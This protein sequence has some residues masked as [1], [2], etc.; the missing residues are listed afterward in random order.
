MR[1]NLESKIQQRMVEWAWSM[2]WPINLLHAIPNGAHLPRKLIKG[3]WVPIHAIRLKKEG[4][5]P[6]VYDLFLPV[7]ANGYHGLYIEVKTPGK[8]NNRS[9][10][11]KE[12]GNSMD[13]LGYKNIVIDNAQDGVD[14]I[15]EYMKGFQK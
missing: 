7:P 1:N 11:Q 4:L 6:G 15:R 12:W 10:E 13:S 2:T 8:I 5:K 14:A 9:K 3:K